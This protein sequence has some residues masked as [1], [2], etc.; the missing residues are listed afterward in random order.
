[1]P[2]SPAP[3]PAHG[4]VWERGSGSLHRLTER[5]YIDIV[6]PSSQAAE[7]VSVGGS[8]FYPDLDLVEAEIATYPASTVILTGATHG[9]DAAVRAAALRHHLE[10]HVY[11]PRFEAYPTHTAAYFARN[12]E[13]IDDATRMVSFWDGISTGTAQAIEYAKSRGIPI[14]IRPPR[15]P[16]S[17]A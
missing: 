10:L 4:L 11:S 16:L 5:A 17:S 7:R 14:S 3:L 6:N 15:A 9:V 8:R 2:P 1:M 13:L 12:E